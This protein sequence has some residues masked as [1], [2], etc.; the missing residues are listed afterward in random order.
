MDSDVCVVTDVDTDSLDSFVMEPEVVELETSCD[1]VSAYCAEDGN[2]GRKNNRVSS[3]NTSEII[4]TTGHEDP[5]S[6]PSSDS[7]QQPVFKVTFR[8]ESV[9]RQYRR[10]I[11]DFLH[12]LLRTKPV[13][14]ADTNDVSLTLEIWDDEVDSMKEEDV[15]LNIENE[16]NSEQYEDN[17]LFTIDKQPNVIKNDLDVPTYGQK[18]EST[19]EESKRNTK[20]SAMP[21]L[22]C[23]N[24]TGYHNMRD[25]PLPRN[26]SVINKNRKEFAKNSTA[27]RYHVS[28]DQRFSH[29]IPGQLSQKLRKALGLKDNQLPKHIYR[30][31][32][33]GY[34]PGWLEEARLQHSG[35]TLFNSDGVAENDVNE[36]EGEIIANTDR[37]QYDVQ[38]IYDFPGFNVP[39]PPGTSDEC[40]KYW[41]PQMQPNHS[42][43]MMLLRLQGRLADGYKRKKLKLPAPIVNNIRN[44]SDMDI[45]DAEGNVMGSELINGHFL[46]PPLPKGFIPP[47][48]KDFIPPLPKDFIPPLPKESVEG[49]PAPPPPLPPELLQIDSDS[50][51][52]EPSL[53]S[54]DDN[55]MTNSLSLSELEK[56]KEVLLMEIEKTN[57][58]SNSHSMLIKNDSVSLSETSISS[59][60]A[61][62][63]TYGR[64]P[65]EDSLKSDLPCNSNTSLTSD[66]NTTLDTSDIDK[67]PECNST[68]LKSPNSSRASVRSTY[69]GTP[70][71][72]STSPYSKLPS[73]E[74]FSKGICD[75]MN[76]E[77]LPDS[78][79][80]DCIFDYCTWKISYATNLDLV[81]ISQI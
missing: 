70:I 20:R 75:V 36:E 69:V 23:F 8:D 74:K 46:I 58:Q 50:Q 18:Y 10:E 33:F 3:P 2:Q 1:T 24:C 44:V 67:M 45:D 35:L 72:S 14:K 40:R 12:T 30:M 55:L 9:S 7:A 62:S 38:K 16:D 13:C 43:N 59:I 5:Q 57:S 66:F 31:R 42:K 51:L 41:A 25:C 26:Q 19:F 53:E 32:E 6:C 78:T 81:V 4:K 49:P 71:L 65:N 37:D 34:P 47:L 63:S 22:N 60:T 15:L 64:S 80:D 17:F 68:P 27:A 56:T 28:E 29:M 39:P 76:F 54:A 21:K 73:S 61:T 79:A 48:P 77:N 11:K 52:Q